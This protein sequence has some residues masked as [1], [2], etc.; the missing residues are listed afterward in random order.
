MTRPDDGWVRTWGAAPHAPLAA[1]DPVPPL[2]G[3]TLRHVVRVS[4]GGREVRV[5]FTNEY[6]T[7]PLV[8]GAA[9]VALSTPRP[10]TF[11]GR[12]TAVVPAGAPLLSDP[13]DLVVPALAE[14]TVSLSLPEPVETATVHGM[15]VQTCLLVRGGTT[16]VPMVVLL[17]AVEVR[18]DAPART[19]VVLGDSIADGVGSTPDAHRRWTDR[20]AERA[21]PA[22]F[23]SNQG[24]GGNRVLN[25]GLGDSASARFD[26][27]VLA[28][29]G[30][31]AVIVSEGIN[32]LA[33]SFGPRLRD[34]TDEPVTTD[35]LIAG[36]R[37]LITRGHDRGVPVLASTLTP[38]EGSDAFTAEGERARQVVNAWIRTGGAFDGVLDFDAVWRDPAH[39]TRIFDAFHEGDHVHGNDDGYRALG[40]SVDLALFR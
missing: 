20:L 14:L 13:V 39:P 17:S 28:T 19:V 4:G 33:V 18:P 31:G 6:G 22:F 26:R 35:D 40:D 9:S 29:P 16:S 34:F 12:T 7:T 30:L 8:I 25:G 24:I 11:S 36:Y 38:F 23:V 21:G 10:L 2:A 1:F 27:D 15:G 37:L 32:D 5:R 3:T